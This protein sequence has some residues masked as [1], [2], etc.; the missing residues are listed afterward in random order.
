MVD[1][2]MCLPSFYL[3]GSEGLFA[4]LLLFLFN[5]LRRFNVDFFKYCGYYVVKEEN[6]KKRN[7]IINSLKE[8]T[9]NKMVEEEKQ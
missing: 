8:K 6:V 4:M 5:T 2:N 9:L 3:L 1:T 7:K